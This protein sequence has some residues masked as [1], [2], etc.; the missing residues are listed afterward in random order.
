MGR[1]LPEALALLERLLEDA[2][3]KARMS[4]VVEILLLRV[5]ALEAQSDHVGAFTSLGSALAIA[6]PEG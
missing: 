6:E 1:F 4:S 2:E 5:L 3:P